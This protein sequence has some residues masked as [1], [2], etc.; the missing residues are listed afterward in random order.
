MCVLVV[1]AGGD[2]DTGTGREATGLSGRDRRFLPIRRGTQ[3]AARGDGDQVHG[4]TLT[5]KPP[6]PKRFTPPQ[7]LTLKYTPLI[8]MVYIDTQIHTPD[9]DGFT[10]LNPVISHSISNRFPCFNLLENLPSRGMGNRPIICARC[11]WCLFPKCS[12]IFFQG[13]IWS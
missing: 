11:H 10:R 4:W 9:H 8:I 13:H 7:A 1:L 6:S 5:D 12:I 2:L 3:E